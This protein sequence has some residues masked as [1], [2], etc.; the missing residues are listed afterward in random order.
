MNATHI[1]NPQPSPQPSPQPGPQPGGQ[2]GAQASPQQANRVQK[3][4]VVAKN[5]HLG[6][7]LKSEFRKMASVRGTI[8]WAILF[9]GSLYGFMVLQGLFSSQ[10]MNIEWSDLSTGLMVFI[11]LAVVY[12][13]SAG[14]SEINNHMQA[15]SFL[16]QKSRWHWLGARFILIALFTI[17]NYAAGVLL[18]LLVV[19]ILPK[20]EFTGGDIKYTVMLALVMAGY[21][22]IAAGIAVITRSRVA[23]LTLPLVWMM[24][25]ENILLSVAGQ[26][27][28]ARVLYEWSPGHIALDLMM[29][30]GVEGQGPDVGHMFLVLALWVVVA[31]G[32]AFFFNWKR[33]VK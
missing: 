6:H 8:I 15:H 16:T 28:I 19:A 20:L 18:G 4:N 7:A 24:V 14:A 31:T 22:L 3:S 13:A 2:V 26:Y 10:P 5:S 12:G 29:N 1:P 32:A 21:A 33:D 17:L 23:G 9:T 27:E 25:I 11:L 30:A